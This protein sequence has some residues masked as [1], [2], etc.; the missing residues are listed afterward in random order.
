MS[1][2]FSSKTVAL[3][4]KVSRYVGFPRQLLIGTFKAAADFYYL[5]RRSFV[6]IQMNSDYLSGK[7]F[8]FNK[9]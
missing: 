6:D 1:F 9:L 5:A 4:S 3:K 7:L 2:G 8:F